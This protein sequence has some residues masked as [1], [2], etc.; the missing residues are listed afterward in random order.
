M[1]IYD[2][3]CN[4]CRH[5]VE[6]WKH[7]TEDKVDYAASQAVAD[8]YPQIPWEHFER[9]VQLVEPD[10]S[11]YEGADAVFRTLAYAP[12]KKWPL[13]LYRR[14]PGF[15]PASERVYRFVADHRM[16]FRR[17]TRFLWGEEFERPT[18]FLTRRLFLFLLG[19][20]YFIAFVSMGVQIK[21]LVGTEGILP[22]QEFLDAV[23]QNVGGERYWRF[24]TLFWLGAGDA[25]LV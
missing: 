3:D 2:G 1:L 14:V 12:Q 17:I 8:L 7:V 25:A 23:R 9:S 13:W 10:G 6:G 22:A 20:I 19:L 4:F 18:Y 16:G 21:G 24:P 11:V 5:W 15:A